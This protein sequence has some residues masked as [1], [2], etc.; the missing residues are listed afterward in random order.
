MQQAAIHGLLEKNGELEILSDHKGRV[1]L[2]VLPGVIGRCIVDSAPREHAAPFIDGNHDT[3]IHKLDRD[4][5]SLVVENVG[6]IHSQK[7]PQNTPLYPWDREI[8]A[9]TFVKI[10]GHDPLKKV[11]RDNNL[12]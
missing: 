12:V 8:E 3:A 11:I 9:V 6:A 5:P 7:E 1:L 2:V 4:T 10:P